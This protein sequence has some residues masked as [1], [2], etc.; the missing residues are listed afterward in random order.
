[1]G[2]AYRAR[3]GVDIEVHPTLL[4]VRVADEIGRRVYRPTGDARGLQQDEPLVR[5]P[6]RK[7]ALDV[8]LE[9]SAVCV[10]RRGAPVTRVVGPLEVAKRYTECAPLLL[11]EHR[12]VHDSVLRPIRL[13]R[14]DLRM[15]GAVQTRL[16][17]GDLVCDEV[18]RHREQ[19]RV[20]QADVDVRA[21][22]RSLACAER[23]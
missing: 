15:R 6:R 12:D 20:E 10:S 5:R 16:A 7:R 14:R 23:E 22:T 8:A 21:F 17:T 4:E 1:A 13:V 18:V 19:L 11:V 9:L 3:F 2:Y